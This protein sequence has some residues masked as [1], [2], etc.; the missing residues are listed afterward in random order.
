MNKIIVSLLLSTVV[1]LGSSKD[2]YSIK[3]HGITVGIISD[4]STIDKG[5]L[6]G[7]PLGGLLSVLTPFDY[8]VIFEPNK[9]PNIKGKNKYKKDKY[10]L[11][12]LIKQLENNQPTHKIFKK[13]HYEINMNCKNSICTYVRLNT[14]KQK[15]YNGYISFKDGIL[16]E[17]CDD[18]SGIC[19]KRVIK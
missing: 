16:N 12:D 11:L 8:Y 9:K 2:Q 7:K 10:L 14:K 1:L 19:F 5:Y 3:L 15:S 6:V 18:E 13:N 17:I 4:F